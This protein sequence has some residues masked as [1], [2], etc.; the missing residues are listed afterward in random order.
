M[1]S[2]R[3][4]VPVGEYLVAPATGRLALAA[5]ALVTLA[6]IVLFPLTMFYQFTFFVLLVYLGA[7]AAFGW[8]FYDRVM[9]PNEGP[10]AWRD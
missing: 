1:Q 9:V 7:F 3:E 6:F 10:E 2:L 5:M 8:F 4:R